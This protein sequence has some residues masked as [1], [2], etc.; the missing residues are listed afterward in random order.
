MPRGQP[1]VSSISASLCPV[2]GQGVAGAIGGLSQ[3]GRLGEGKDRD[4]LSACDQVLPATS[5]LLPLTTL[6]WKLPP[7][8]SLGPSAL[9]V[10]I[11]DRGASVLPFLWLPVSPDTRT[12]R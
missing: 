4:C 7:S 6:S 1:S 10:P 8:L 12:H 2:A 3:V 9:R 5:S 11:R